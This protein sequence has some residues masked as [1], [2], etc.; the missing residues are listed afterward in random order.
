[1]SQLQSL[2]PMMIAGSLISHVIY[3]LVLGIVASVIL[4]RS[5]NKY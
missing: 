3:G 1:M 4:K 5:S 2:Q